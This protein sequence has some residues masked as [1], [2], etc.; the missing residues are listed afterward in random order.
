MVDIDLDNLKTEIL[1]YLNASEFAVF[2]SAPG[3]LD[4]MTLIEWDTEAVPDYRQF[5][6]AARKAGKQM[7]FFSFR[8]FEE[9]EVDE[10]ME[11]LKSLELPRE[12]RR[13]LETRI[14]L[15]RRHAGSVCY[16]E[17]AFE[18]GANFYVYGAQ[19][20]WHADFVE[21]YDEVTA[22]MPDD[23]F[24]GDS[25]NLGGYYSNN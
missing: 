21:A 25:E 22:L 19:P 20:D 8:E 15:G 17:L 6:D 3:T 16:L 13:D 5:L 11:D 24:G 23:P 2:R 10:A 14:I 18:H 7:I 1:D 4:A 12:E 9:S